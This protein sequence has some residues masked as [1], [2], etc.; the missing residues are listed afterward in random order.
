VLAVGAGV[1]SQLPLEKGSYIPATEFLRQFK[2]DPFSLD[3]GKN[4]VVVGGGNTAMDAARAAKQVLGVERVAVVYRRTRRYMPAE[5]EELH[6]ALDEGVEFLELLSPI[7]L[8][9]GI[10][11]CREMVLGTADADGRLC[12]VATKVMVQVPADTV[13]SALGEK[14]DTGFYGRLGIALN[15]KGYP[16][17]TTGGRTNLPQVYV[18]GDGLRGPASVVDAI[19]DA[20]AAV[21]EIST[22]ARDASGIKT[23]EKPR[24]TAGPAKI[25]AQ[26][27]HPEEVI[28]G[29]K[30]RLALS[31]DTILE[32]E[33]CLECG[34]VCENCA[35]VCPNRA[36][37]SIEIPDRPHAA[38]PPYGPFVQQLRQL[39][40][41][42]SL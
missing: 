13:V 40:G 39:C 19:A 6:M 21:K 4:V 36:N 37:V 14:A 38:D 1:P 35:D 31:S 29:K 3:L 22:A 2:Q 16:V 27:R 8:E 25:P 15:E 9:D 30:G 28:R 20:A 24:L 12:P 33:R 17:V 32:S 41:V 11:E 26:Y 23:E 18:I 34:A 7:A 42:L 5:K 10:L